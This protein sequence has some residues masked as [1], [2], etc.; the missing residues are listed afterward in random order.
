MEGRAATTAETAQTDAT[1]LLDGAAAIMFF[2][3]TSAML[4]LGRGVG[5]CSQE[6]N[7]WLDTPHRAPIPLDA[8]RARG[9]ADPVPAAVAPSVTAGAGCA[10]GGLAP[11]A[12]SEHHAAVDV[13]GMAPPNFLAGRVPGYKV[14][15]QDVPSSV[16]LT[17]EAVRSLLRHGGVASPSDVHVTT[18]AQSGAQ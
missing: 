1:M 11:W 8:P 3:Q 16:A 18:A 10:S 5:M 14:L 15:I 12:P 9:S 13:S 6:F 2:F 7:K 17:Q 4:K